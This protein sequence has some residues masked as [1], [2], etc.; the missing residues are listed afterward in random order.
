MK[1]IELNEVDQ[2]KQLMTRETQKNGCVKV[3]VPEDAGVKYTGLS[4][5]ELMK[6]TSTAG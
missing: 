4:K 5:E 6:M 2:E 3:T 1:D